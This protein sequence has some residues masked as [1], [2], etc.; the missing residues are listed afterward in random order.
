MLPARLIY[1]QRTI[2]G[3]PY[4]HWLS[5]GGGSI[6]SWMHHACGPL[7]SPIA[8]SELACC[9]EHCQAAFKLPTWPAS[10]AGS[11]GW[12]AQAY[13]KAADAPIS[14]LVPNVDVCYKL[15]SIAGQIKAVALLEALVDIR[16]KDQL[17]LDFQCFPRTEAEW[18]AS[19]G[20]KCG[21]IYC[22][23]HGGFPLRAWWSS[24]ASSACACY[25]LFPPDA[26][27]SP[28]SCRTARTPS[29]RNQPP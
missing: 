9:S 29:P 25:P 4:Y 19:P 3:K 10:R 15:C 13:Y 26:Q 12:S 22:R 11:N 17:L 2:G 1:L 6:L 21:N 18:L 8:L 28:S 16:A 7:L 5:Y 23:Q 14:A 27:I 24:T 20:C